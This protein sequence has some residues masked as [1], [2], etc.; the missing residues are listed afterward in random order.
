MQ[1]RKRNG[2]ERR[3]MASLSFIQTKRILEIVGRQPLKKPIIPQ[4]TIIPQ[5][6]VE[7]E[8]SFHGDVVG[9]SH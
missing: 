1:K 3:K 7:R 6:E 4:E 2:K 9:E 5:F 8:H